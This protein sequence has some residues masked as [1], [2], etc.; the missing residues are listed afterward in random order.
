MTGAAVDE[1]SVLAALRLAIR[2]P[3][4]HNSQ[5][6]AWRVYGNT[7][8]LYADP[9]RHIPATDPQGR[10]L[11]MS[12]G[13]ALHHLIV[14]LAASGWAGH[15]HRL[16]D[17]QR[18][19]HLAAVELTPCTPTSTDLAA[20]IPRRCT[21]RR[22]FSSWPVPGEV[23]GGMTELAERHGLTLQE[24]AEPRLRWRL[25]K[26]IAAGAETQ[27]ADPLYAGE[28]A[29]WSGR[30]PGAT[31]GVPSANVPLPA[32]ARGRMPMRTYAR[33]AVVESPGQGEPENAALLLLSTF[34]DTRASW[35]RAGEVTSA[36]LL[37]ATLAGLA[38]SPL[39]QPLEV[40]E[41]RAFVR[42]H[43]GAKKT[44]HPHILLRLGWALPGARELPATPR[45][46]VDD[47]VAIGR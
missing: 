30:L 1:E 25:Y 23:I 47:V 10:D 38:S 35:L 32:P 45:R 8:D 26:A 16:P 22:R 13:A 42:D 37:T 4:V 43:V 46:P 7:V 39:T 24:V 41:T 21:D 40:H 17:P 15:V 18:P 12:C 3:S 9:S 5:P 31:D 27:E 28:I 29:R 2:A 36:I 20:V 11:V 19:D 6:W 14:A 34:T 33:P 44:A